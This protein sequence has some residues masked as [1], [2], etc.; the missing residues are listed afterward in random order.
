MQWYGS[1]VKI[2]ISFFKRFYLFIFRERGRRDK[3]RK[4]HRCMRDTSISC[5]LHAPNRGPGLQ[6]RHVPW[7]GV[8]P[9]TFQFTGQ[10]SVRWAT[11]ARAR[12]RFLARTMNICLPCIFYFYVFIIDGT[13]YWFYIREV[14]LRQIYLS[15]NKVWFYGYYSLG[16]SLI[17]QNGKSLESRSKGNTK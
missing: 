5:L 8:E 1:L 2:I 6:P 17:L 4:K 15:K 14:I 9:A 10:H 7:L 16:R 11:L 3:E 13:W 12:Q